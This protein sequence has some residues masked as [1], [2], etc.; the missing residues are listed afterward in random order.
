MYSE[1]G[2]QLLSHDLVNLAIHPFSP[3][4]SLE[5]HSDSVKNLGLAILDH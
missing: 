2:L 3:I 5:S 1:N 4:R